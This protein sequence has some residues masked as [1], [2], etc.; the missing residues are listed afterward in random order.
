MGVDGS[1][2]GNDMSCIILYLHTP[3]FGVSPR[4][5]VW[6]GLIRFS[7]SSG[8]KSTEYLPAVC[9]SWIYDE[10]KLGARLQDVWFLQNYGL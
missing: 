5:E 7:S 3:S 9:S 8:V 10:M 4:G 6:K 1:S 2:L